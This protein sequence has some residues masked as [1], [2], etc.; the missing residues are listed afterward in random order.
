MLLRLILLAVFLTVLTD[1]SSY[2]SETKDIQQFKA[3]QSF[4]VTEPYKSC[5][6]YKALSQNSNFILQDLALAKAMLFCNDISFNAKLLPLDEKPWLNTL[7]ARGEVEQSFKQKKWLKFAEASKK[8]ALQQKTQSLSLIEINKAIS[9]LEEQNSQL[10]KLPDISQNKPQNNDEYDSR[11]Q[12][13]KNISIAT[14]QLQEAKILLAPRFKVESLSTA[15]LKKFE[16]K[17]I[18]KIA[19]DFLSARNFEKAR[20]MAEL[21]ANKTR[22]KASTLKKNNKVSLESQILARKIIRISYKIQSQKKLF[23]SQLRQDYIWSKKIKLA[24]LEYDLGLAYARALWTEGNSKAALLILDASSKKATEESLDEILYIQ[25]KISEEKKDYSKALDYYSKAKIDLQADAKWLAAKAQ[26]RTLENNYSNPKYNTDKKI[27]FA[28]A[29]CAWKLKKYEKMIE[30]LSP[31]AALPEIENFEISRALYWQ[32]RAEKELNQTNEQKLILE[33]LILTDPMGFYGVLAY[34]ELNRPFP[35]LKMTDTNSVDRWKKSKLF[36]VNYLKAL[37]QIN[38][39]DILD[40]A[41]KTVISRVPSNS[42]I[43]DWLPLFLEAANSHQ[44]LPLFL[45]TSSLSPENRLIL[46]QQFPNLIFPIDYASE[47]KLA[48]KTNKI[49]A[50]FIFSIIRQESAF[51]PF[52]RSPADAFGLM[53]LLPRVEKQLKKQVGIELSHFEDLYNPKINIQYGAALL[54][55]LLNRH[56]QKIFLAAA[57]YNASESALKTWMQQRWNNDVVEFIEEIPYEETRTYVKLVLRNFVFYSR[58]LHIDEP[59]DFPSLL[60]DSSFNKAPKTPKKLK[61][62]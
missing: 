43:D 13:K 57:A 35:P 56:Q 18:L 8:W 27:Q 4:E 25:G 41:I 24:K 46:M 2:A 3:A 58:L 38:E 52:A 60:I 26:V 1:V 53:Q 22:A 32:A 6:I 42:S 14:S 62:K 16:E 31:L 61:N 55:D 29:W 15:E 36:D 54:Q 5:E 10:S 30:Y 20:E 19:Q 40:Q 17:E 9:K 51:D 47:I 39:K 59:T 49:P 23:L 34:A 37:A 45:Q 33:K 44:Y 28:K 50:E 7:V 11:E 48:A 12:D 21:L